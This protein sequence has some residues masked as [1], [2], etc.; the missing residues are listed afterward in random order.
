MESRIPDAGFRKWN[1]KSDYQN[2]SKG[3]VLADRLDIAEKEAANLREQIRQHHA[4]S[5]T[6][7]DSLKRQIETLETRIAHIPYDAAPHSDVLPRCTWNDKGRHTCANLQGLGRYC[8]YHHGLL[9]RGAT[10]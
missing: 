6:I 8:N 3:T 5:M 7:I 2:R 1:T 9:V 4:D 10:T